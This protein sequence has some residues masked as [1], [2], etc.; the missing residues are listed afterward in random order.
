[1]TRRNEGRTL[2]GNGDYD[3]GQKVDISIYLWPR[4]QLC[5]DDVDD[6][7]VVADGAVLVAHLGQLAA[8]LP[9]GGGGALAQPAIVTNI[10]AEEGRGVNEILTIFGEGPS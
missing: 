4:E 2:Q 10:G 5:G 7:G 8:L 6:P 1:M 3:P 9:G